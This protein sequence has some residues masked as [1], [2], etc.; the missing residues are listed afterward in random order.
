M[1]HRGARGAEPNTGDGAGIVTGLPHEFLAKVAKNE[2]GVDLPPPGKYAAGVVFL[3]TD[4]AE[5]ER[6]KACIAQLCAE[7]GQR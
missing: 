2:F 4:A 3:P 5:R 1:D 6:C 7:E